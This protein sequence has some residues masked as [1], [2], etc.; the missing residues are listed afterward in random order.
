MLCHI[1][2]HH[3]KAKQM[4]FEEIK[5]KI[6]F[7]TILHFAVFVCRSR[8]HHDNALWIF[9]SNFHAFAYNFHILSFRLAKF[10]FVSSKRKRKI[11]R[12]LT[13]NWRKFFY[14]FFWVQSMS[15]NV[16]VV[17]F[18]WDSCSLTA[19]E[20]E[21]YWLN[22]RHNINTRLRCKLPAR[23]AFSKPINLSFFTIRNYNEGNKDSRESFSKLGL[24]MNYVRKLFWLFQAIF[25][26]NFQSNFPNNLIFQLSN[27]F[28]LF[29]FWLLLISRHS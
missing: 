13:R 23:F 19:N 16:F 18:K 9:Q 12:K 17:T 3:I 10:Y 15:S 20:S 21:I 4:L 5:L 8:F 27:F 29:F 11:N 7:P 1:T 28:D 25:L 14:R 2:S 24:Y 26:N 6:Y 22:A